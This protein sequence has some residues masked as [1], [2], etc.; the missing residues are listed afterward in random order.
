LPFF[1]NNKKKKKQKKKRMND[2]KLQLAASAAQEEDNDD[3]DVGTCSVC[4]VAF[5]AGEADRVPRLLQCGHSFCT[6]CLTRCHLDATTTTNPAPTKSKSKSKSTP[7][8]NWRRRPQV[9]GAPSAAP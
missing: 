3:E 7:K 5:S 4:L 8:A 1:G 9:C 6:A 2:P